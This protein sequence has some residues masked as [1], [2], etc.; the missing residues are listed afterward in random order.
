VKKANPE[1]PTGGPQQVK[2]EGQATPRQ[3]PL[4]KAA[5]QMTLKM[6]G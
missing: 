2:P 1:A 5:D 4:A 6:A 3:S